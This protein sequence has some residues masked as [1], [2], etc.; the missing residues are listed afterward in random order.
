MKELTPQVDVLL[1]VGSRNSSNTNRLQ[2]LGEQLGVPAHRIDG[3]HEVQPGWLTSAR[4]IGV[5]AGASAPESLVHSVVQRLRALGAGTVL[6]V[7]GET[8]DVRFRLPS[9]LA[10]A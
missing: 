2:E 3:P 6:E 10:S 8:E 9:E 1:V 5:T 4:R 7:A